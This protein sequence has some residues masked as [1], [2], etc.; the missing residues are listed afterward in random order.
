MDFRNVAGNFSDHS[1]QQIQRGGNFRLGLRIGQDLQ[2]PGEEAVFGGQGGLGVFQVQRVRTIAAGQKQREG[3]RLRVGVGELLVVGVGKQQLPP[4]LGE[5]DQRRLRAFQCVGHV[6][7]EQT[8]QGGEQVGQVFDILGN[9]R[10]PGEEVGQQPEQRFRVLF[11]YGPAAVGGDVARNLD[12]RPMALA[13][14][15]ESPLIAVGVDQIG[16]GLESFPLPGVV[17][18]KRFGF[19]PVP[20]AFNSTNPASS[21]P[22]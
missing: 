12:D 7:A 13:R 3:D 16:K 19:S 14:L 6:V 10:L 1:Q 15:V 8:T 18:E 22:A 2:C 5:L 20:V 21:L 9:D 11:G 4:I 17:A